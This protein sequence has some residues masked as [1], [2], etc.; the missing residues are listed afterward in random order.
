MK[1]IIWLPTARRDADRIWNYIAMHNTRA[2]DRFI[3]RIQWKLKGCLMYPKAGTP[4]D[5]LLPGARSVP[6][7]NYLIFYRPVAAGVRVLRV[8]D[9]RRG[10]EQLFDGIA[11]EESDA[12]LKDHGDKE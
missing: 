6:V 5:E 2:A 3:S 7:G 11:D 1:S 10:W 8:W 9:A 4:R 12:D